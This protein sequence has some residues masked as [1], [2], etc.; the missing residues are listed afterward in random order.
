MNPHYW[1]SFTIA[2]F[3]ICA[4]PG[5]NM[6]QVM[7]SGAMHGFRRSIYTMLGCF[8]AVLLL[9]GGSVLGV[10][11]LL[12]LAP[13]LFDTLRITG[14]LY[15]IYLGVQAW[16]NAGKP[17]DYA[18]REQRQA[19][20]AGAIFRK[21]FLV[22]ISNPKALFFAAAFF[23]QFI[24]PMRDELP[25]LLILLL[26][27]SVLEFGCYVAYALGGS[28]MAAALQRDGVRKVFQRVTGS[29]FAL[30]GTLMIARPS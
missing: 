7:T 27:F 4:S 6:L 26:T 17:E 12:K 18:V 19:A 24:D 16:R 9:I 25:Q 8:L 14:A 2:V 21:G 5:P 20:S 11:A 28:R 22:G 3:F 15:L 30:F 1:W 13:N 29:L 23:P 10:G